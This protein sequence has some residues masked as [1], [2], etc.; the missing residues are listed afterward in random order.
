MTKNK[1]MFE[2]SNQL[3]LQ[4]HSLDHVDFG[5]KTD[6]METECILSI[7]LKTKTIKKL[8]VRLL[9]LLVMQGSLMFGLMFLSKNCNHLCKA[10]HEVIEVTF[11][12]AGIRMSFGTY[13]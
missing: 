10:V 11:K 2:E 4:V 7:I 3:N 13:S 12:L 5:N 1:R 8:I 6:E 9:K